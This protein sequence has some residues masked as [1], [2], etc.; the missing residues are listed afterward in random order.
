M[1]V[2]HKPSLNIPEEDTFSDIFH[3]QIHQDIEDLQF[4]IGKLV[5]DMKNTHSQ[6][7]QFSSQLNRLQN[8]IDEFK[9][10]DLDHLEKE[11]RPLY[12][13][14]IAFIIKLILDSQVMIHQLKEYKTL[15]S[16]EDHILSL[17]EESNSLLEVLHREELH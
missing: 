7:L 16:K 9:S 8:L 14:S 5:G 4:D 2:H 12:E 3:L 1:L 13:A 10:I 15:S 17:S 6:N 11:N